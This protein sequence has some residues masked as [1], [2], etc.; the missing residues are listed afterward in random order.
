MNRQR[1]GLEI[2]HRILRK[3]KCSEV[4]NSVA[5]LR[6]R[7]EFSCT[8]AKTRMKRAAGAVMDCVKTVAALPCK[9]IVHVTDCMVLPCGKELSLSTGIQIIT[10]VQWL[11]IFAT[12]QYLA[13][14]AREHDFTCR[15][16]NPKQKYLLSFMFNVFIACAMILACVYGFL[17]EKL[18]GRESS[19]STCLLNYFT[20]AV[21]TVFWTYIFGRPSV[22]CKDKLDMESMNMF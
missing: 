22:M 2:K 10:I 17:Y 16:S 14:Y 1:G 13:D 8:V 21:W 15:E 5:K 3:R 18:S 19:L 12:S 20:L 11:V 6:E 9:A 7:V 4:K